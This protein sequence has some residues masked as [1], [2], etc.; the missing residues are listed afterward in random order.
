ME[1][2]KRDSRSFG[3]RR[4]RGSDTEERGR[5]SGRTSVVPPSSGKRIRQ[6]SY[7]TLP[8][9]P[10]PPQGSEG[11]RSG[12]KVTGPLSGSRRFP[13]SPGSTRRRSSPD[14]SV[15]TPARDSGSPHV[16]PT[17]GEARKTP[18]HRV[19]TTRL[20][21]K[22]SSLRCQTDPRLYCRPGLGLV[23]PGQTR[24]LHLRRS[25]PDPEPRVSLG[26]S[27]PKV[28]HLTPRVPQSR[29][30]KVSSTFRPKNH[31]RGLK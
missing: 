22:V 17:A 4:G 14:T 5:V 15:T 9:P 10:S 24:T 11:P 2:W 7:Q 30:K 20:G 21:T 26:T 29:T 31:F 3:L 19:R 12:P 18:R 25:P 27:R 28:G 23:S 16:R 6:V 1:E 8:D 13:G